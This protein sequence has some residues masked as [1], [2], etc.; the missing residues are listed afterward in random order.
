M[1]KT[2]ETVML[3]SYRE[4]LGTRLRLGASKP[5]TRLHLSSSGEKQV[6]EGIYQNRVG[7][8]TESAIFEHQ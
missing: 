1:Q 8:G 4:C 3:F 6:Y 7:L 2:L 5:P